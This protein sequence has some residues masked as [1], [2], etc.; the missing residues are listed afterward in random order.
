MTSHVI[1]QAKINRLMVQNIFDYIEKGFSVSRREFVIDG[2]L[3]DDYLALG[4]FFDTDY[5]PLMER[6]IKI[7]N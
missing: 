3:L 5:F 1:G 2:M 6:V 7:D 4:F